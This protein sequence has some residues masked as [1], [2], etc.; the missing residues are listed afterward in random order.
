[1]AAVDIGI[2]YTSDVSRAR[3]IL[4]EIAAGDPD[5]MSTIDCLLVELGS[6]SVSLRARAWCHDQLAAHRFEYR[7]YEEAKRRFAEVGTEIPYPYQN[8]VLTDGRG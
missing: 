4:L 1:M 5:V 8:V 2:S 3:E 6:S 7:L